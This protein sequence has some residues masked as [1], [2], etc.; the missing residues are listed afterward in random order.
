MIYEIADIDQWRVGDALDFCVASRTPADKL[1]QQRADSEQWLR[2]ILKEWSPCGKIGYASGKVDGLLLYVPRALATGR[3]L[4]SQYACNPVGYPQSWDDRGM[5]IV[6]CLYVKGTGRGLGGALLG[7][8]IEELGRGR[9][10][11]GAVCREIGVMVYSPEETINWPAGPADFYRSF[12][13][14]V[15]ETDPASKRLWLTRPVH[16]ASAAPSP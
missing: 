10:F 2:Q 5:V 14:K 11:R 8:M 1:Q 9:E 4:C 16:L 3:S 12:G 13:F 7:A 15:E 6:L